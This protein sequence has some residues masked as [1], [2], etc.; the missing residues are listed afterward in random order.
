VRGGGRW[1]RGKSKSKKD[2][3]RLL[4]R[5]LPRKPGGGGFLVA[6]VLVELLVGEEWGDGDGEGVGDGAEEF[7]FGG[8]DV[9]VGG[10]IGGGMWVW[11]DGF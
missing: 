7:G 5:H 11:S 4:R 10:G 3:L 2:P 9:V 6:G 1:Q 8:G